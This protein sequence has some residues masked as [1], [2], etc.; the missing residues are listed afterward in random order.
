MSIIAMCTCDVYPLFI[1][2]TTKKLEFQ[3]VWNFVQK[4]KLELLEVVP[5]HI[6]I[7]LNRYMLNTLAAT[8]YMLCKSFQ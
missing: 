8:L 6:Q 1:R 5:D 3:G 4:F 7:Y 2:M